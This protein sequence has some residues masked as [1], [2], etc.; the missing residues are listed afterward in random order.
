MVQGSAPAQG[1]LTV[2]NTGGGSLPFTAQASS[3][4]NWLTLTSNSGT[5]T[6][7]SAASLPFTV[8]A[9][10]GIPIG[11]RTG[12]ITVRDT[13]SGASQTALVKLLVNGAQQTIQLSQT[14][15][16]FYAVTKAAT[17]PAQ[18][19]TVSSL[20]QGTMSWTVEPQTIPANQS[21]LKV[22]PGP[23][24]ASG[25]STPG[26][27]GQVTIAVDQK[28]LLPGQYYGTVRINAPNAANNPQSI[29]VLLNVVNAGQFWSAPGCPPPARFSR[30]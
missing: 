13:R 18:T 3:D 21:W 10:S 23:P 1:Q 30:V 15:L 14:G 2:S 9:S 11:L 27:P 6:P 17:L 22:T 4:G 28:D 8:N 7:T 19:L 26:A 12:Q 20:G 24:P 16:T 29:S 5:A 25:Q